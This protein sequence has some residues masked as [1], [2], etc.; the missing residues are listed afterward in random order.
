MEA[1]QWKI[2]SWKIALRVDTNVYEKEKLLFEKESRN[3]L[4]LNRHIL[5]VEPDFGL[6]V[7]RTKGSW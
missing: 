1:V 5:I 3:I 2:K 7:M 6:A 4:W